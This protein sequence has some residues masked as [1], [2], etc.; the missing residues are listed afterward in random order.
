[1]IMN[2]R[3]RGVT[4][5]RLV[6][7]LRRQLSLY[8]ALYLPIR[9]ARKPETVVRRETELLIEG[10]P[11]SGN[12][13]AEALIRQ[14]SPREIMLA[15][16]SHAV[17]HVRYAVTLGVPTVILYRNP[18]DAVRSYLTL[19]NNHID[20][21]DAYLDYV[22]FYEAVLPLS[23]RGALFVSF[24]ELTRETVEVVDM[25]NDAFSLDL[26]SAVVR[27]ET[28]K[29]AVYQRMD[30]KAARLGSMGGKSGSR[31]GHAAEE[32]VQQRADAATAIEQ[33]KVQAS[34]RRANDI[35]QRLSAE[36]SR[37]DAPA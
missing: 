9:R 32:V 20:A 2:S 12:T 29:L 11:R 30:E 33:R 4:S 28:G 25:L 27:E 34:R 3:R 13:W 6:R 15:H 14:C 26:D 35:Y 17:A 22:A 16:H 7:A 36:F 23:G 1:M 10:F 37:I 18:D 24:E 19:F 8:P 5:W 21:R 31:P